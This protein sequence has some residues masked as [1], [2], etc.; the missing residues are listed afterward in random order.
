MKEQHNQD[1]E[2]YQLEDEMKDM[3]SSYVVKSP[4]SQDTKAL[5]A[6]LQPTFNEIASSPEE[7]FRQ[8]SI[9]PPSFLSQLKAQISFY[10]WHFWVTSTLIFVMLTLFSSNVYVT[11]AT[12]FYQFAIPLSMLVGVFYTYQTW[13][14]QMRIIESITPFPPALLLLSRMVIILAMNILMGIIGSFYLSF[15]VQHFELLPFLL[16]WIAPAMLIY[17]MIA[18]VMMRKGVKFGLGFGIAA[19]IVLMVAGAIYQTHGYALIQFSHSQVA[20]IQTF[21]VTLGL[22]LLFLAYKKSLK[23]QT[24]FR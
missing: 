16:D 10:Q 9:Q 14:K 17:G 13:N 11:E 7:E 19:W 12:Q 24:M 18:Y 3:F 4:S 15:K 1:Q 23:L 21:L 2:L 20:G 22:F 5:L 8:E 6:A